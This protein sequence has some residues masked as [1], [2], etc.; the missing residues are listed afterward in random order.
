MLGGR[1]SLSLA[2]STAQ[3][4]I[5]AGAHVAAPR[6]GLHVRGLAIAPPDFDGPI[7]TAARALASS[8]PAAL[9]LRKKS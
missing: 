9:I 6:I 8:V 4:R 2:L 1:G 3:D 7:A 5:A